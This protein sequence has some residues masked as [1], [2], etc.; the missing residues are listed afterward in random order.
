MIAVEVEDISSNNNVV[1]E[2]RYS[3]TFRRSNT[4]GQ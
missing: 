1:M 4:A 2:E 3:G